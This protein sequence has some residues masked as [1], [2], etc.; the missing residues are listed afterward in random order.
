M[1]SATSGITSVADLAGKTIAANALEGENELALD[2]VLKAHGVS[3]SSVHVVAM[4]FPS[5]PAAL[6]SGQVQAVTVVEPFVAAIE[7]SGGKLLS[8]LFEGMAPNLLV[9]GYFTTSHEIQSNLGLVKRFVTAINESL[10]YAATHSAAVRAI[11]PTYTSIPVSVASKLKLPVWSSIIP[12]GT[13]KA[14]ESLMVKLGWITSAPSLSSLIWS[15]A[16][17]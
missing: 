10:N 5:M 9:A 3:P 8:P 11:I 2:A 14:Q 12:T 16:S 15:G 4:P 17:K 1:V 7:A 6:A 13:V